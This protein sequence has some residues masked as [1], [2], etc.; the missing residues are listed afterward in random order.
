MLAD[1]IEAA[2]RAM[3]DHSESRIR[4]RIEQL[5]HGKIEDKQLDECP[6][7]FQELG[8]IRESFVQAL[9]SQ[10][11]GRVSYPDK[12]KDQSTVRIKKSAQELHDLADEIDREGTSPGD[13]V[14]MNTQ[15]DPNALTD[16]AD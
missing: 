1:T 13:T 14:E 10:Y 5:I 12:R 11:H 9:V 2:V 4:V 7:T 3:K 15:G 6:L 16:P 8:M